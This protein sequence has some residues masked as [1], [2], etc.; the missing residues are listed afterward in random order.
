MPVQLNNKTF[1]INVLVYLPALYP[2]Y[3][4]EFYIHK[5]GNIGIHNSY[6]QE[7]INSNNL[8]INDSK[9]IFYE[10]NNIKNKT[11]K[12][13]EIVQQTEKLA[14]FQG[15]I[16]KNPTLTKKVGGLLINSIKAKLAILDCVNTYENDN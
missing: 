4:P 9:D 10:I 11:N 7:K 8:K 16:T 3:S 1:K 6:K 2:N 13:D 15:G 14:S 5:K 12:I